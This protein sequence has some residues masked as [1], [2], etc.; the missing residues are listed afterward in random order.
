VMK[1]VQRDRTGK[2]R[3]RPSGQRVSSRKAKK[4]NYLDRQI[5]FHVST[6][7]RSQ[8]SLA[9]S[10]VLG[11]MSSLKVVEGTDALFSVP[12]IE[13]GVLGEEGEMEGGR[14]C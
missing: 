2:R 8:G 14:V 13:G 10:G 1:P 11:R 9:R 12:G 3:I 5:N 4:K 7:T 6:V